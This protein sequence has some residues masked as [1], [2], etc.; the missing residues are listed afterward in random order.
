MHTHTGARVRIHTQRY[1]LHQQRIVLLPRVD[2]TH[3]ALSESRALSSTGI[4]RHTASCTTRA[5]TRYTQPTLCRDEVTHAAERKRRIGTLGERERA[6][7]GFALTGKIIPRVLP[8]SNISN[9]SLAF[10]NFSPLSPLALLSSYFEVVA[11]PHEFV[12]FVFDSMLS[13]F[14]FKKKKKQCSCSVAVSI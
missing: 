2:R 8:L 5:H 3:G 9:V 1:A 7:D 6:G 14:R 13:Y 4:Q 10:V 11:V 12:Q